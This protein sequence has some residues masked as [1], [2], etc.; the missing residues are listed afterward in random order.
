MDMRK[1]SESSE[2]FR[3]HVANFLAATRSV[4]DVL[5]NEITAGDKAVKGKIRTPIEAEMNADPEMNALVKTRNADI[6][7][8]DFTLNVVWLPENRIVA[9]SGDPGLD[10]FWRRHRARRVGVRPPHRSRVVGMPEAVE[11]IPRAFF[12]GIADQDAY[13]VC[14]QHLQKVRDAAQRCV[15]LYG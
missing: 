1:V 8:G 3:K 2:T 7:D 11:E 4:K 6:H 13:A 14:V 5:I 12:D 10:D 9:L 15:Q